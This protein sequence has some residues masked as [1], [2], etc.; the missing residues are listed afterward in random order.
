MSDL[1][2][3]SV[4]L[5]AVMVVVAI[6]VPIS[7]LTWW[8]GWERRA[9]T[10]P[11][12]EPLRPAAPT[13]GPFLIYLSGIGDISGAYQTR[14]EDELLAAIAERV[15]GL[16]VITDIFA[17]S[18]RNQ[19]LTEH[20]R[21]GWF[22]AWVHAERL[23]KRGPIKQVGKLINLRNMLHISVSADHRYGPVY[24]YGVAEMILQGLIRRGYVPGSGAPIVLLGYSGGGQVALATAGYVQATLQAPVQ[25]ISLGG[26]MNADASLD[27][28]DRLT[29]LYGSADRTHRLPDWIL[30][31]RWPFWRNSRWNRALAA[32]RIQRHCLGP[33]VHTGRRSYLD[34]TVYVADGRSYRDVTADA[35]GALILG[36]SEQ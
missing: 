23:R 6:A 33:M 21:L 28:I 18:V 24:N 20:Q 22:W 12:A 7:V 16:V 10:A 27:L 14:F 30:P 15:P 1:F 13:N 11:P 17:F 32:G 9:E 25:V 2:W 29:H 19:S 5:L 36:A 8:A 26:V 3:C 35:I 34:A 4:G 31:A